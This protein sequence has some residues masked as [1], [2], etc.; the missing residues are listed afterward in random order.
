MTT[1]TENLKLDYLIC[2]LL[3][4]MDKVADRA[5]ET[6]G[7]RKHE[8]GIREYGVASEPTISPADAA[9]FS[10][11]FG[12]LFEMMGAF[13]VVFAAA[14]CILV[15]WPLVKAVNCPTMQMRIIWILLILFVPPIGGILMLIMG[16]DQ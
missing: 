8:K 9:W 3:Y 16:C 11:L 14:V 15:I 1:G 7:D 2:P 6:G 12:S 10:K 13:F 5:S 4:V